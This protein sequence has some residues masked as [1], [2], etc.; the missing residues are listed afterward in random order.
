MWNTHA[1][2]D[3]RVTTVAPYSFIQACNE[4]VASLEIL[5]KFTFHLKSAVSTRSCFQEVYIWNYC[6]INIDTIYHNCSPSNWRG[7]G[8]TRYQKSATV[9]T[10]G[11][12][13]LGTPIWELDKKK[14]TYPSSYYTLLT[15]KAPITTAADDIHKYF[16][17]FF[18][19]N[20][21]WCFKWILC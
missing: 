12:A 1:N 20:K 17:L 4:D 11:W 14:Y 18:R 16:S 7:E 8:Q 10:F 19:E 2:A 15:I 3:A 5:K 13:S 21:T 9:H 6:E